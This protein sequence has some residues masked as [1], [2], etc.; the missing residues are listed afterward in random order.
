MKVSMLVQR[1]LYTD[2]TKQIKEV[3]CLWLTNCFVLKKYMDKLILTIYS[4]YLKKFQCN[5][6][7]LSI[8]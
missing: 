1:L 6:L 4:E 7:P 2:K 5:F 3:N 8:D